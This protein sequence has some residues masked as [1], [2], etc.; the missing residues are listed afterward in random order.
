MLYVV[1]QFGSFHFL[2]PIT[3]YKDG[4]NGTLA[5]WPIWVGWAAMWTGALML[6]TQGY[7]RLSRKA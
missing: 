4:G 3:L 5:D 2:I 7:K 1:Y 6:G